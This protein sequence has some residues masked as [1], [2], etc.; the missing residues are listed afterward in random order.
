VKGFLAALALLV[1]ASP[2][3]AR[4]AVDIV[5]PAPITVPA[6]RSDQELALAVHAAFQRKH[7]TV[8][9]DEPGHAVMSFGN[10]DYTVKVDVTYAKSAVTIRYL[11]STGLEYA[12][13]DGHRL[14]HPNYNRWVAE[15][16]RELSETIGSELPADK[17]LLRAT[18]TF[19][20]PWLFIIGLDG[21]SRRGTNFLTGKPD[22]TP[23]QLTPGK[24]TMTVTYGLSNHGSGV[25]L[26]LVAAPGGRYTVEVAIARE[27]REFM[28]HLIDESTGKE[29]GGLVGSDNEPKDAALP[30]AQN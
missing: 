16:A 2:A 1:C 19:R 7:W 22:P 12:E 10:E 28:I 11:D 23:I 17:A 30:P 15:V 13:A 9:S 21:E 4:K 3:L 26:W 5:D 24:H 25:D 18:Y 29:S 6:E 27:S 20:G 8:V 14:I